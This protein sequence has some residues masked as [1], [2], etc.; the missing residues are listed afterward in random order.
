MLNI[1]L[2]QAEV[3]HILLLVHEVW[4]KIRIEIFSGEIV[5][6]S[7]EDLLLTN[8]LDLD[9]D[10]IGCESQII[11]MHMQLGRLVE[12]HLNNIFKLLPVT[13]FLPLYGLYLC[14]WDP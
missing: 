3:Y 9:I 7:E 14:D 6:S 12:I 5:L 4:D 8:P 1:K 2:E 10:R 11:V 13:L